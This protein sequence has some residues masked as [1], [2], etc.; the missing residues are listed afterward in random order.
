MLAQ[1]PPLNSSPLNQGL[2]KMV[3]PLV[4]DECLVNR[5][6][7]W[8]EGIQQGMCHNGELYTLLQ[9]FSADERLR[10]YAMAYE[11]TEKGV[12]VCITVSKKS[13]CVW[14]RLRSLSHLTESSLMPS[15]ER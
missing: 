8:K 15:S 11:Q 2:G 6:K 13:Y 1:L 3:P 7:Y 4:L 12:E 9:E 14:L 5:F 10:A